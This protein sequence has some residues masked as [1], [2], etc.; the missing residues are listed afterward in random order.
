MAARVDHSIL[1]QGS[2][3]VIAENGSLLHRQIS[4]LTYGCF[5]GLKG[6]G[7]IFLAGYIPLQRIPYSL[8]SE[9]ESRVFTKLSYSWQDY[10]I[11]LAL[12]G[13]TF[14]PNDIFF[15]G[16]KCLLVE[17]I[18][19]SVLL[20]IL[21]KHEVRVDVDE[22]SAKELSESHPFH[23]CI[24][25]PVIEEC[26]YRGMLQNG[27]SY[28]TKSSILGL[29]VPSILFGLGHFASHHEGNYGKAISTG[30]GGLT[31]GLINYHFGILNAI[32]AHSV[33]NSF[34]SLLGLACSSKPST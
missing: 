30:L 6:I 16:W 34:S 28:L 22:E 19:H 8:I 26:F 1:P 21:E 17:V 10:I 14:V 9:V 15:Y 12:L 24:T 29:L 20:S 31:L 13:S 4:N 7:S 25:F 32:Y 2:S 33:F 27:L 11:P 18:F 23:T 5:R 3:A